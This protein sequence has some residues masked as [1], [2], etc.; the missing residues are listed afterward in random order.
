MFFESSCEFVRDFAARYRDQIF[1]PCPMCHESPAVIVTR[2]D[3]FDGSCHVFCVHHPVRSFLVN[4]GDVLT[5]FD[6]AVSRWN[7]FAAALA[8]GGAR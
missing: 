6:R 1:L 3:D 7:R 4:G 2:N 8:K 5:A